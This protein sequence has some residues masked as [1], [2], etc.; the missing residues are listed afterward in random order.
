M[1]SYS[2]GPNKSRKCRIM[3]ISSSIKELMEPVWST[4]PKRNS[5]INS[6]STV[7]ITCWFKKKSRNIRS[8]LWK[9]KTSM[10]GAATWTA[11]YPSKTSKT[12]NNR[13]E[14]N[15]P[16]CKRTN[17]LSSSYA[18]GRTP[19]YLLTKAGCSWIQNFSKKKTKK[20]F[21][22]NRRPKRSVIHSL[23]TISGW[24]LRTHSP[25]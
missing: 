24:T 13:I 11:N 16:I 20:T 17:A 10:A 3:S 15:Y 12:S 9:C 6:E 1:N 8:I 25:K 22:T 19:V 7:K 2:I 4:F 14:S 18:A 21:A 23:W 5:R